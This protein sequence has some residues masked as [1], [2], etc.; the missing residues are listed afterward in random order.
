MALK[1]IPGAPPGAPNPSFPVGQADA[2]AR[3]SA[4]AVSVDQPSLPPTRQRY[5]PID[6][7]GGSV[8]LTFRII[9]EQPAIARAS[10][11]VQ[12]IDVR[13][14][15]PHAIG[16]LRMSASKAR[17]FLTDLLDDSRPVVATGDEDGDVQIEYD[18]METGPVLIA[19]N[20][21]ERETYHRWIIDGDIDLKA[22]A[23]ELLA[24]LGLHSGP[25]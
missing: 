6:I 16:F 23:G 2:H 20:T 5:T 14:S 25:E 9:P 15:A 13:S 22:M 4:E 11:I 18:T 10:L 21:G 8:R 17:T 12:V 1:P 7:S 3:P 24:D 19:R